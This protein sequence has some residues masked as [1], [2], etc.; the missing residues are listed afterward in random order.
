[1][2]VSYSDA[3]RERVEVQCQ[4][5]NNRIGYF[6]IGFPLLAIL[7]LLEASN[8]T[9]HSVT[10]KSKQ[11]FPV[12]HT[13]QQAFFQK[14]SDIG[15]VSRCQTAF[16]HFSLCGRPHKEKRENGL[17]S[18][19]APPSPERNPITYIVILGQFY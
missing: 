6:I 12:T 19:N 16:S 13:Y 8:T 9:F 18:T 1:M 3:R 2:R 4:V 5:F 17:G 14:F 15:L 10:K 7:Q 11:K